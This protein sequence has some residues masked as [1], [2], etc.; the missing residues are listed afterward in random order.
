MTRYVLDVAGITDRGVKRDHNED[1]WSVPPPDLTPEQIVNKG[2]LYVVADGVGGHQ[3]GDVASAMAVEIVQQSYYS[4]PAA[5]AASSL[6]RAIQTANEQIYHQAANRPEQY[7]MSSTVTAALLRGSELTVANV[8]DSRTCLIRKGHERQVTTDHTWVE[9]QVR[10]GLI[11]HE[12]AAKHPHRNI[13]TRALG[14]SLDLQVDI[15]KERVMPGDSVLLCSDGLSNMVSGDEI[16][17][18]VDQG[19]KAEKVAHELVELAK[20]RGAPDNVTAVLL[21]IRKT[22]GG[23]RRRLFTLGLSSAMIIMVGVLA[24]LVLGRDEENNTTALPDPTLEHGT[25]TMTTLPTPDAS[26]PTATLLP[27]DAA[28]PQPE[29]VF[30]N[31]DVPITTGDSIVFAWQWEHVLEGKDWQ[32]IFTLRQGQDGPVLIQKELPLNQRGL[33]LAGSLEPGEYWWTVSVTGPQRRGEP[34]EG[35]LIVVEPAPTSNAGTSN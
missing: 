5:D 13:I 24:F 23:I 18:I 17:Q 19:K 10:A 26:T 15:F 25:P 34:A 22:R 33:E 7:G 30:V 4:D 32:F 31:Q 8:G 16:G 27:L 6:T 35:R 14:G 20:Q 12:E 28:I 3:A 9:E 2:L 21:N 29:L 1:A 11:T